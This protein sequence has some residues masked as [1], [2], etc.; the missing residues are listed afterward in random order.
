MLGD[1]QNV[2]VH[3]KAVNSPVSE[4]YQYRTVIE[5]H[6]VLDKFVKIYKLTS[7]NSISCG[8]SEVIDSIRNF[9]C[10]EPS[11]WREFFKIIACE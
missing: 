7:F 5:A 3:F 2:L 10:P 6:F 9:I 1:F 4:K 8:E 11:W